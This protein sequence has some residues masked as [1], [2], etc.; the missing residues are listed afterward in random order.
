MS[1]KT[2]DRDGAGAE[3][4]VFT[5]STGRCGEASL[6]EVL[7]RHAPL[8]YPGFEEPQ[9]RP[10][11]PSIL[12]TA[13]RHF[14]RRWVETDA[15]LG[16]G[17]TLRAAARGDTAF[18]ERIAARR[19][20]MARARMRRSGARVYFDI[21]KFF[22]R[23]LHLGF[24]RLLPRFDIVLLVRDP[25]VNMR[26]YLNRHKAFAKDSLLP[27][28][29]SNLLCMTD[30]DLAPGELYLWAWFETYLRYLALCEDARVS[31]SATL[32]TEH[33]SDPARVEAFLTALDL[34]HEPVGRVPPQNT[35][36]TAGHGPTH[37]SDDDRR[38]FERF[39]SRVPAHV[40]DR[41]GYLDGYVPAGA[42]ASQA[43]AAA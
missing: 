37:V 22:V 17:E 39:L 41:I 16:R 36:V 34:P 15:L 40:V 30:S 32:R 23:G 27:S 24:A 21:S 18:L 19:L 3:R 13:E 38:L 43:G 26:S 10:M 28:D 42:G 14:R 5:A 8:V 35:N 2:D 4:F 25:V 33:L 6:T 9:V 12:G 7:R 20:Q 31:R 11:L 1:P 29:R